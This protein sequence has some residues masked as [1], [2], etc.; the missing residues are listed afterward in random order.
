L[1]PVLVYLLFLAGIEAQNERYL[2]LAFP[3]VGILLFP[4]FC[5]VWRGLLSPFRE[6]AFVLVALF[7]PLFLAFRTMRGPFELSV[8]EKQLAQD[9]APYKQR[10]I[11]SFSVDVALK[12][13]LP[14]AQFFN[15][16]EKKYSDFDRSAL[17]LFN[18]KAFVKEWEGRNPMLNWQHLKKS[19]SL[20]LVKRWPDGWELYEI[21]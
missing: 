10:K 14:E 18:E 15:L 7:I 17:V 1:I 3:L 12:Q 16:W 9:M 8:W 5:S 19:R 4:G 11:Y 2:L 13:R 21:D 6:R 20:A